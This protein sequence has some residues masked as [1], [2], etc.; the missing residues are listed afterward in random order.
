MSRQ[1]PVD[2]ASPVNAL[3]TRLESRNPLMHELLMASALPRAFDRSI[4]AAIL[5]RTT[6]DAEFDAAFERLRAYPLVEV[7]V[8][9]QLALHDVI[10]VELLDRWA[11]PDCVSDR[12]RRLDRL[13]SYYQAAYEDACRDA[14]A[15]AEVGRVI[16]DAS[17]DRYAVC[18]ERIEDHLVRPAIEAVNTAL[19][20]GPD[21]GLDQFTE[22]FQ[23]QE[24]LRRFGV[25]ELLLRAY[26]DAEPDSG[27]SERHS[28]HA[29]AAYYA[30]RLAGH[31][32]D[33]QRAQHLVEEV[34]IAT[35]DDHKIVIWLK[36][37]LAQALVRQSRF[38]EALKA[39]DDVI[40]EHDRFHADDWNSS[41]PWDSK[42]SIYEQLWDIPERIAALRE[43]TRRANDAGNKAMALNLRLRI[44]KSF[45]AMGDRSAAMREFA[46]AVRT[47]RVDLTH[48]TSASRAV[49]ECGLELLGGDS[50]RMLATFATLYREA[51]QGLWPGGELDVLLAESTRLCDGGD[52]DTAA[53][54]YE[55]AQTLAR[56]HAP[57]RVL[58][59]ATDWA[60]YADKLGRPLRG[61]ELNLAVLE[62][63]IA[64]ADIWTQVRCLTHASVLFLAAADYTRALDCIRRARPLWEGMGHR[65]AVALSTG[66]EA[67]ILR[68]SG[69][70]E[71]ARTLI[72]SVKIEPAG[73]YE[74]DIL[75]YRSRS[76][77]D[78]SDFEAA[79]ADAAAAGSIAEQAGV[80][81][82]A[83]QRWLFAAECYV[84]ARQYDEAV[85]ASGEANRIAAQVRDFARWTPTPEMQFADEHAARA[86]A[87]L[88]RGH[89]PMPARLAAAREHLETAMDLDPGNP[90][91]PVEHALI[92][93]L[94]DRRDAALRELTAPAG[95]TGDEALRAAIVSLAA[96]L[97]AEA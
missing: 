88:R 63:P 92:N 29:W 38:A 61:A 71:Q 76:R 39:L 74:G 77:F 30:A 94:D 5:D 44:A 49:A 24:E 6:D 2:S 73:A 75:E 89:G 67:E 53:R 79:G 86:L 12:N 64:G 93:V 7:R 70:R 28:H 47:A 22:I 27:E 95:S 16:R 58:D 15:L 84:A 85:H 62:D 25:C 19:L 4:L 14:E 80:R 33:W 41:V 50:R 81:V 48:D 69:Q 87:I 52:L 78:H 51:S 40:E 59:I 32:G 35:L 57:D 54:C 82:D 17:L 65:R 37:I 23:T 97:S 90:W 55:Q 36:G 9:G 34:P 66:I 26:A 68:R 21:A 83:V 31:R 43:A 45:H 46:S 10:R 91:F 20:V 72:E 1:T 42:A 56:E 60:A 8:N 18:R 13:R 3:V 11:E 96:A